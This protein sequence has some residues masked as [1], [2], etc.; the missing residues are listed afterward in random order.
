MPQ[1]C[2]P[3]NCFPHKFHGFKNVAHQ[4]AS[5]KVTNNF[6][7]FSH[8]MY[9]LSARASDCREATRVIPMSFH[10][11][12]KTLHSSLSWSPVMCGFCRLLDTEINPQTLVSTFPGPNLKGH[13]VSVNKNKGRMEGCGV[14]TQ[15]ESQFK[16]YRYRKLIFKKCQLCARS[17]RYRIPISPHNDHWS[18]YADEEIGP[19]E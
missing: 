1:T 5:L 12:A 14:Y 7:I 10:T 15:I 2:Y 6:S 9:K 11:K 18:G 17:F 4:N 8:Q 16:K 3:L 19:Q 13:S